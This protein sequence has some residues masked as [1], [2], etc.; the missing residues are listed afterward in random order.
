LTKELEDVDLMAQQLQSEK[1]KLI[2][3]ADRDVAHAKVIVLKLS[4]LTFVDLN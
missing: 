1:D 2:V 3:A 4:S